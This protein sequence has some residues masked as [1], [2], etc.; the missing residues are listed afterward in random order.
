MKY[1]VWVRETC[2]DPS[3]DDVFRGNVRNRI[4]FTDV[5]HKLSCDPTRKLCM[6][7]AVQLLHSFNALWILYELMK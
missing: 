3:K 2:R 7:R 1:H 4:Y 5:A 6:L